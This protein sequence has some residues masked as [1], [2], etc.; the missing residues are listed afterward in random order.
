[1]KKFL[2]ILLSVLLIAS[3]VPVMSFAAPAPTGVISATYL[4]MSGKEGKLTVVFNQ[5]INHYSGTDALNNEIPVRAADGTQVGVVKK[6]NGFTS[7]IPGGDGTA[8]AVLAVYVDTL[9]RTL[10]VE[11]GKDPWGSGAANWLAE[12][13]YYLDLTDTDFNYMRDSNNTQIRMKIYFM[14]NNNNNNSPNITPAL[15]ASDPVVL[16]TTTAGTTDVSVTFDTPMNIG[17]VALG[18]IELFSTLT[19]K[20]A[21]QATSVAV[22]TDLKTVT[23]SFTNNTSLN[24]ADISTVPDSYYLQFHGGHGVTSVGGNNAAPNGVGYTFVVPPTGAGEPPVLESIELLQNGK[25]ALTFD[26][27]MQIT[28]GL[29]IDF[30]AKEND[31][32]HIMNTSAA[33]MSLGNEN[34]TIYFSKRDI[35]GGIT[36]AIRE[37][38]DP[39][40]TEQFRIHVGSIGNAAT[41]TAADGT[42]VTLPLLLPN[43]L[44]T[45]E[46]A[47]L[48]PPNPTT[49]VIITV[50]ND[51]TSIAQGKATYVMAVTDPIDADDFDHFEWN[52]SD[53][54]GAVSYEVQAPGFGLFSV[55]NKETIKIKGTTVG[56]LTISATAVTTGGSIPAATPIGFEITAAVAG[57]GAAQVVYFEKGS[58]DEEV[59][60]LQPGGEYDMWIALDDIENLQELVLPLVFDNEVVTITGIAKGPA[61]IADACWTNYLTAADASFKDY[62]YGSFPEGNFDMVNDVAD[63]GTGG[64]L[65]LTMQHTG[66]EGDNSKTIPAID[67][68]DVAT[69]TYFIITFKVAEDAA[70]GADPA[71]AFATDTDPIPGWTE[72]TKA[73]YLS[74]GA[75]ALGEPLPMETMIDGDLDNLAVAV[76][77]FDIM[78]VAPGTE[79]DAT[80]PNYVPLGGRFAFDSL[81]VRDDT[82]SPLVHIG[83]DE[84]NPADVDWTCTGGRITNIDGEWFF[85]ADGIAPSA[86]SIT[87]TAKKDD[88]VTDTYNFKVIDLA[89]VDVDSA[90]PVDPVETTVAVTAVAITA[91]FAGETFTALDTAG[92]AGVKWTVIKADG[93]DVTSAAGLLSSATTLA[94]V[95]NP[96]VAGPGTY[97]LTVESTVDAATGGTTEDW[98]TYLIDTITI[99]VD[100]V[101]YHIVGSAALG[102]KV[103]TATT[104]ATTVYG[105][106]GT[107]K[108]FDAGIK[109][110]LIKTAAPDY[111]LVVG[112]TVA[113]TT[114]GDFDLT[115]TADSGI[116]VLD[117]TYSLRYS[118]VGTAN[119]ATIREESYLIMIQPIAENT[120]T[121]SVPVGKK[122]SI[123]NPVAL[124]AGAIVSN[125]TL[126]TTVTEA[127]V[128]SVKAFIGLIYSDVGYSQ[129]VD[130]NEYGGGDAGEGG[131]EGGDLNIVRLN[132]GRSNTL[133]A[134]AQGAGYTFENA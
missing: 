11:Y 25:I 84:I 126:K 104:A 123:T 48:L 83:A 106:D 100:G 39:G 54:N 117:G 67:P 62:H 112:Y 20:V 59:T 76:L 41:F 63:A 125:G 61:F 121:T 87:V 80:L 45:V 16:G 2:A 22:S 130:I 105:Y 49:G 19:G 120:V 42:T 3:M 98:N 93:T 43:S 7:N 60:T 44:V 9:D 51:L 37:L 92:V 73:Q 33:R 94:T 55:E 18:N 82:A 15:A 4:G 66:P 118:R 103:R 14:A 12:G 40:N 57:A 50:K 77:P 5:P 64:Q 47:P 109:V 35:D 27:A 10:G 34:K 52:I 31:R 53:D 81:F 107:G 72:Y 29:D 85:V 71:F 58:D 102:S 75:D 86:A 129:A 108:T 91:A 21:N 90:A 30:T 119:I 70:A 79:S 74:V 8:E 124:I 132:R 111:P 114:Y 56:P 68:S 32:I 26:K 116:N 122:I 46:P 69:T 127:D 89:I 134:I 128:Q 17:G 38:Y 1:M 131:I 28:A 99:V 24:T 97:V 6:V 78:I 88:T 115:I 96:A 101:S 23:F 13:L 113:G 36:D 110:E 95:F 65:L 133:A